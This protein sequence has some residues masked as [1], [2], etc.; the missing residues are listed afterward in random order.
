[1]HG[2][3]HMTVHVLEILYNQTNKSCL[4]S[5]VEFIQVQQWLA[6]TELLCIIP[7]ENRC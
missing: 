4:I 2:E 6:I 1:M 7:V 5:S 3:T